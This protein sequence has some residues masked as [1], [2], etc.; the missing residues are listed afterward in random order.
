MIRPYLILTRN[1]ENLWIL[2]QYFDEMHVSIMYLPEWN[3]QRINELTASIEIEEVALYNVGVGNS[4]IGILCIYLINTRYIGP[5]DA[6]MHL[7]TEAAFK[8]IAYMHGIWIFFEYCAFHTLY[9]AC[10][11]VLKVQYFCVERKFIW[12][13]NYIPT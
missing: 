4:Y 13:I 3:C 5:L 7:F 1:C 9:Y 10:R 12:V 2:T 8:N 6:K 11:Y